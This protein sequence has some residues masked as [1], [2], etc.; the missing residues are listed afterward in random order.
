[1]GNGENF[2]LLEK[3]VDKFGVVVGVFCVVVDVGFVLNDMQV[4]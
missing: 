2:S 1:M 3:V 4:G